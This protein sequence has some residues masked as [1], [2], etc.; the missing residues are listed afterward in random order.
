MFS[1]GLVYISAVDLF[2]ADN[3]AICL[4]AHDGRGA[5]D[6]ADVGS[7]SICMH[8]MESGLTSTAGE[9][10]AAAAAAAAVVA[11]AV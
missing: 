9:T 4:H 1:C 7:D 6:D 2:A 11:A 10:S 5:G 8:C 3:K